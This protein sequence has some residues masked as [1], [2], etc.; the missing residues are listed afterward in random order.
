MLP[1]GLSNLKSAFNRNSQASEARR[2]P[3][4]ASSFYLLLFYAVECG[5]K[6]I[7]LRRNHLRTIDS[8]P[9]DN[10]RNSHDLEQWVQELHL[11][12]SIV[13][14]IP[15]VRLQNNTPCPIRKTHQA[16]RYGMDLQ[17]DDE[18]AFVAWL[19]GIHE[20]IKENIER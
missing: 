9:D 19:K 12:R 8:I 3:T 7:Y 6:H 13:G 17:A 11:P 5:L 1:T 14:K 20:W 16:W 10:L 18:R 2:T 15:S 4:N